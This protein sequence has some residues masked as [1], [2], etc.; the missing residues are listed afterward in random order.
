[1]QE[2]LAIG[3][4]DDPGRAIFRQIR[5]LF[6]GSDGVEARLRAEA[7][8]LIDAILEPSKGHAHDL[9]AGLTFLIHCLEGGRW[10]MGQFFR[11][12]DAHGV[13]LEGM[14]ALRGGEKNDGE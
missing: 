2:Q 11:V 3:A 13:L 4:S 8:S 7:L 9:R 1:M 6:E 14:E 12:L 10:R 5:G